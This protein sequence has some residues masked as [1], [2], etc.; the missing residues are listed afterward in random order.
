MDYIYFNVGK[1]Y[2]YLSLAPQRRR[3]AAGEAVSIYQR[4]LNMKKL[5]QKGVSREFWFK[6]PLRGSGKVPAMQA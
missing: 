6:I 5:Y 1:S 2:K 4:Y 3:Q